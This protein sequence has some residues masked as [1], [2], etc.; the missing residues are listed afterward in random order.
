MIILITILMIMIMNNTARPG[1][2]WGWCKCA[3][4][5]R[6]TEADLSGWRAA[7]PDLT[8]APIL[9]L[10]SRDSGR[11]STGAERPPPRPVSGSALLYT[12]KQLCLN[13]HKSYAY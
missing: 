11:G 7:T 2:V 9:D 6:S 5:F 4:A 3:G 8:L 12:T 13:L 1:R 10:R